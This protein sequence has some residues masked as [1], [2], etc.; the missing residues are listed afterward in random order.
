MLIELARLV[1]TAQT[2]VHACEEAK[3]GGL[4]GPV[5]VRSGGPQ[6]EVVERECI[7]IMRSGVEIAGEH[8]GEPAGVGG[9]GDGRVGGDG[10]EVLP[11]GGQPGLRVGRTREA[12]FALTVSGLVGKA[13][14]I[15]R[16]A[17]CR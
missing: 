17:V 7:P 16:M 13:A 11:F 3:R 2:A 10:N 1:L 9:R 8:G 12:G 14:F 5:T 4:S 15:A 6:R